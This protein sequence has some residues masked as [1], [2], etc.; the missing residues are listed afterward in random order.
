MAVSATV[1]AAKD[2]D[3]PREQS[4]TAERADLPSDE[5]TL[6]DSQANLVA[7]L[8]EG[9]T[10]N[11]DE[12]RDLAISTLQ[13]SFDRRRE[14]LQNSLTTPEVEH[15]LG[16]SRQAV[17]DRVR[18]GSLLAIREN[19]KLRYPIWQF[20]AAGPD[21]VITGLPEVIRALSV[22]AFSKMNWL[23]RPNPILED[24]TPLQA[25]RCGDVE[26]VLGT[27]RSVGIT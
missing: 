6:E 10:Y 15:L 22:P 9:R 16:T 23:T 3:P 13:R 18:C 24:R 5:P 7:A 2:N 19:G 20:D 4:T 25:L 21:R 11:E 17:N 1:S 26:R 27:A 12:R 8:T 14:I